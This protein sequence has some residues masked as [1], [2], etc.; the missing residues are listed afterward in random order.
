MHPS[1]I[2]PNKHTNALTTKPFQHVININEKVYIYDVWQEI[3]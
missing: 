3:V 2:E 1:R